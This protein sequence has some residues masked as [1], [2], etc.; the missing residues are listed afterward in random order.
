MS[1]ALPQPRR[2][3]T[4][5]NIKN[6]K[7]PPSQAEAIAETYAEQAIAYHTENGSWPTNH[8]KNFGNFIR[9]VNDLNSF[10]ESR[11]PVEWPYRGITKKLY[12]RMLTAGFQPN[13]RGPTAS[14]GLIGELETILK[15]GEQ[16]PPLMLSKLRNSINQGKTT[17]KTIDRLYKLGLEGNFD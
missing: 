9:Y 7:L 4:N 13:K 16:P 3:S 11:K 6:K 10:M 2:N 17:Q 8:N 1:Y 5:N 12:D 15:K 14:T